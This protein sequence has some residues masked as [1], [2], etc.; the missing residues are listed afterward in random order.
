MERGRRSGGAAAWLRCDG[1]SGSGV[2]REGGRGERGGA[3]TEWAEPWSP[4]S[5]WS[6]GCD[7]SAQNRA[8]VQRSRRRGTSNL[9]VCSPSARSPWRLLFLRLLATPCSAPCS[10]C[11]RCSSLTIVR[12][13]RRR[14]RRARPCRRPS[15]WRRPGCGGCALL[16]DPRDHRRLVHRRELAVVAH[17][18]HR[19]HLLEED[20]VADEARL[21]GA[22]DVGRRL[23]R[24]ESSSAF[25]F[26]FSRSFCS[27]SIAAFTCNTRELRGVNRDSRV[28]GELR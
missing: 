15:R 8:C 11:S 28:N 1:G 7:A 2:T 3:H 24:S 5:A 23:H 20:R 19:A 12:K 9:R 4:D 22:R 10:T 27:C 14:R 13:R 25:F 26:F 16:L 18:F 6:R 17:L 21:E